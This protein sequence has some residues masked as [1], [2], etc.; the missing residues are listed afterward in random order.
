MIFI[1][2]LSDWKVWLF[3]ILPI[4][5]LGAWFVIMIICYAK[6]SHNAALI[7]GAQVLFPI[8]IILMNCN[9]IFVRIKQ[10]L[11][12][13]VITSIALTLCFLGMQIATM[14]M[15][16][17]LIEISQEE[18]NLYQSYKETSYDDPTYEERWDAWITANKKERDLGFTIQLLSSGSMIAVVFAVVCCPPVKQKNGEPDTI[19]ED[20]KV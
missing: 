12:I 16:P 20:N 18:K 8:A 1:K 9:A 14:V 6:S 5:L 7:I 17:E 13:R 3:T 11:Y 4:I 2:K 19:S 10:K 15:L